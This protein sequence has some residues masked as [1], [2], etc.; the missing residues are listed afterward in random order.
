MYIQVLSE[1]P[2]GVLITL[3]PYMPLEP[4]YPHGERGGFVDSMFDAVYR[5]YSSLRIHTAPRK[6]L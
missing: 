1:S 4:R 6:V 2:N 5:D 3:R